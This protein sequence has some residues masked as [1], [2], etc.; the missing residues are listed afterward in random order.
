MLG[1]KKDL[2]VLEVGFGWGRTLLELAW[3]FW[4]ER[5]T[6]LGVDISPIPPAEKREDLLSI[7]RKFEI[8]PSQDDPAFELPHRFFYD[9]TRLPFTGDVPSYL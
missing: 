7:S 1:K 6:F 8:I 4:N 5:V 9:A 2:S 3:Y